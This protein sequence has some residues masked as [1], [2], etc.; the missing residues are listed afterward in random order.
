MTSPAVPG[1]GGP[2]EDPA[3]VSRKSGID[4]SMKDRVMQAENAAD[5]DRDPAKG[6]GVSKTRE[7]VDEFRSIVLG[8]G[9]LL[10]AVLPS[11]VFL[12]TRVLAGNSSAMLAALLIGASI[13]LF[14]ILRR[15]PSLTAVLGLVGS[16]LAFVVAHS[17]QRAE[18]FFLPDMITSVALAAVCLVSAAIRRPLVAWTSHLVRRWPRGWYWHPRVLPAYRET[19]LAWAVFFL[20]QAALQGVLVLRQ[21]VGLTAASSLLNGWPATA[22]LLVLTYL[23]GTWRLPRLAGPSVVEFQNGSPPPWSGQRRGF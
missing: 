21:D 6:P 16:L 19:T 2:G 11:V 12:V 8:Q 14:R 7:V 18:L 15:Q 20:L 17:Y 3:G 4:G 10:D 5:V 23:Y 1:T 22:V 13:L 9:R